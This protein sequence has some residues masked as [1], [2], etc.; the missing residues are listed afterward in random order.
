MERSP[1]VTT[2]LFQIGPVPIT[3]SVVTTWAIMVLLAA[4]SWL[5]TRRLT[6]KSSA[7]QDVL[8]LIVT[9]IMNQI[10]DVMHKDPL[11]FLPLIGTLFIFLVVANISDVIP[12]TQAPTA[13]I[14]TPAAL[15]ALVFVSV[16][17]FGIRT[18]GFFGYLASFAKPKLIMLPL[19]IVF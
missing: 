14:E 17:Y 13:R 15:A 2:I 5:I 18:L 7:R 9:S 8:E 19:N 10:R 12:G 3:R 6:I 4:G 16:H 1:L 11:P